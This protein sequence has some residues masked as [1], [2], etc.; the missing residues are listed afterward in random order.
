MEI[1]PLPDHRETVVVVGTSVRKPLP[2]LR[3]YL[4]SL[5]WQELPPRTKVIPVFVPDYPTKDEAEAYLKDW[6]L[7]RGGELLRGVPSASGDFSDTGS[8]HQWSLPATQRIG[9][10]KNR[11]L[12]RALDLQA[13]YVFLADAD[14]ILDR[15]VLPQLL[16]DE[17][18]ITTAVYWTKWHR[19]MRETQRIYVMPQVW[20]V[21][22]YQLSGRGMDDAE[23]RT[24]LIN[25]ELTR[26][27]GF[28]ACTLIQR[29]VLEAG[30]NFSPLPDAPQ[31]GLNAWEDRQFSFRVERTHIEAFADPFPDIFHVYDAQTDPP[32][33]PAMVERLGRE[34]PT[35][36]RIGDLVSLKLEA[37]EPVPHQTG[38]TAVPRQYPRGRL[39][40]LPLMPEIEDA[41]LD[42]TRGETRTVKVHCPINHPLPYMRG[43]RRLIRVT[44]VDTKPNAAPVGLEDEL[45]IGTRGS[46]VDRLLLTNEQLAAIT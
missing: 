43:R 25:R 13:D 28:G 31:D 10:N 27:W 18:L 16:A 24:K 4:D 42:M 8:T 15:Y 45:R 40:A 32:Q 12:K 26:V 14:L 9:Q 46:V 11:I 19:Q 1:V 29:K 7:S 39:G 34:H 17:K 22:P 23:F 30:V 41:I 36:A 21:N 35:K 38:W 44:L 5:A 3:A 2:I 37:L 6:T 20:L 33:I